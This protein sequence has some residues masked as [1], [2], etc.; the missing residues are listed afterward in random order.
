MYLAVHQEPGHALGTLVTRGFLRGC[1]RGIAR[2]GLAAS[3]A[4]RRQHK[5]QYERTNGGN[6]GNSEE[7]RHAVHKSR[8]RQRQMG[9]NAR[10]PID[11]LFNKVHK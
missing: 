1:S 6:P 3:A 9:V 2:L 10:Q 4:D 11:S 5:Q 8:L 7:I